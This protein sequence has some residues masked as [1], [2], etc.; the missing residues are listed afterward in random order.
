MANNC[1][2][3]DYVVNIKRNLPT[4]VFLADPLNQKSN[5]ECR[6]YD[7]QMAASNGNKTRNIIIIVI[8]MVTLVVLCMYLA[9]RT[10][11]IEK[12]K[13]MHKKMQTT[14]E[15][16]SNQINQNQST[17]TVDI[18]TMDEPIYEELDE[19]YIKYDELWHEFQPMPLSKNSQI[20]YDTTNNSIASVATN[21]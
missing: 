4:I 3:R 5:E 6:E 8:S 10:N 11:F 20:Q 13:L 7:E 17:R 18:V 9:C 1:L 12:L 2:A 16:N 21:K 14:N 19:P 15:P